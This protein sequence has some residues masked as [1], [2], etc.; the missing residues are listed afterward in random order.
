M[1]T[2]IVNPQQGQRH[3]LPIGILHNLRKLVLSLESNSIP[4]VIFTIVI[5]QKDENDSLRFCSYG[6]PAKTP[7]GYRESQMTF[8]EDSRKTPNGLPLRPVVE[9]NAPDE[10]K[11]EA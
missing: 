10:A 2:T 1:L 5:L 4:C 6:D 3:D 7:S 9:G 8:D 11:E